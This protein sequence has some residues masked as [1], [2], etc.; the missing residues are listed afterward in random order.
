MLTTAQIA[1]IGFTGKRRA[2]QRLA[3]LHALEVLDRFRPAT[4]ASPA[5]YHWTLGP[6]GAALIA[7]ET[8]AAPSDPTA[9]AS[10]PKAPRRQARGLQHRNIDVTLVPERS[11]PMEPRTGAERYFQ[12][13]Q[14]DPE[15]AAAYRDARRR[16][17]E[18]D[19]IMQTIDR[20]RVA[21]EMSKAELARRIGVRPEAVRRLF[22]ARGANPTL[23]TVVALARELD[24]DLL[25]VPKEPAS[26]K[27]RG[28]VRHTSAKVTAG[29]SGGAGTRR[30]S[31]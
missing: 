11:D 24:L 25:A 5:P 28:A 22:A 3:E 10:G 17:A 1:D 7:A 9:T 18:I 15:Y 16:I 29:P 30:R 2:R 12:D 31:A 21:R 19:Q 4:W 27:G 13:R 8:G 26:P 14:R 20:Q 6:F 23:A